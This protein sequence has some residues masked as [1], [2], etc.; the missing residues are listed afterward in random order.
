MY[1]ALSSNPF[2][3]SWSVVGV[4]SVLVLGLFFCYLLYRLRRRRMGKRDDERAILDD[5]C[6]DNVLSV[7]A[8]LDDGSHCKARQDG[9][10]VVIP[11]DSMTCTSDTAPEQSNHA[12]TTVS[13]NDGKS[14]DDNKEKTTAF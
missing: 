13:D 9:T 1:I 7:E 6:N 11:I 3:A 12:G 10:A 4:L 5:D 2:S 8:P 14:G